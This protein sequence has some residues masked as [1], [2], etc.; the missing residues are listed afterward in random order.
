MVRAIQIIN[1][2]GWEEVGMTLIDRRY[3]SAFQYKVS[4]K[5]IIHVELF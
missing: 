1:A 3:P 2:I 4:I 5:V